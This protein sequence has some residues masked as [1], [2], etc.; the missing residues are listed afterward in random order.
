MRTHSSWLT[1]RNVQEAEQ[2]TL[3]VTLKAAKCSFLYAE[4][5]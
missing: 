3:V 4:V 2:E 1:K 5:C